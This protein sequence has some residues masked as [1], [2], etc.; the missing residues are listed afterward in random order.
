MLKSASV[1]TNAD[2]PDNAGFARIRQKTDLSWFDP[3]K[4]ALSGSSAF[5]W[6]VIRGPPLTSIPTSLHSPLERPRLGRHRYGSRGWPGAA[7]RPAR[8]PIGRERR[9]KRASQ[10]LTHHLPPL[11]SKKIEHVD[12]LG[13]RG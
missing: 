7:A 3:R 8:A 2:D 13:A 10:L 1:K 12:L 4:P 5:V 9:G 11:A 6:M